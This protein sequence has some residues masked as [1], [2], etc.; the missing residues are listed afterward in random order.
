MEKSEKVTI[1]SSIILVGFVFGVF[2]HYILGFYMHGGELLNSFLYPA[3]MAFCDIFSVLTY[4]KDFSP[5]SHVVLW[6]AYFPLTY[7]LMFP[8][9][10]IKN[11]LISY[12]IY[13]S[14][15]LVYLISMNIKVFACKSLTKLQNFQNIFII[16]TISYPVLY[17]LDKGNFDMYLFVLFGFCVYAFKSEK[18]FI[19]CILLAIANA[20]KPFTVLFL[21]LF[22]RKKKYKEFFLSIILTTLLV[23]GGF[24]V[25]K[26]NFFDQIIDFIKVQMLFKTTYAMGSRM[27]IG[28]TSSLFMPLKAIALHF[29]TSPSFVEHFVKLYDYACFVITGITMF[30]IWKENVLWKQLTLMICNFLLLPYCTYDYK[31]IFLFIPIWLFVKEEKS[32]FDLVYIILFGLL[33]IPKNIILELTAIS[34][35]E[36]NLISLSAILN[37][38]IMIM[39]SLLI[40]YEQFYSKKNLNNDKERA[41]KL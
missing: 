12:S 33:F 10:L 16:T 3:S 2:Y 17:I 26:G 13:I 6:V 28:F 7:L 8:F 5:Y 20:M 15:F 30:F 29:S 35:T 18:Y 9:A 34:A 1:L 32:H 14:G 37:P 31:L 11:P 22:L 23:I 40:I 19:S 25:F 38:I 21:L 39:L 4:I 24:M 27:A 41:L 36:I